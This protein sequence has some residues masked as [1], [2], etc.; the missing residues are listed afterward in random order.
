[1]RLVEESPQEVMLKMLPYFVE[2]A[3]LTQSEICCM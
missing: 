3:V 1:M 2:N